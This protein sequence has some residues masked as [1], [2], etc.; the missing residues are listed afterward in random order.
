MRSWLPCAGFVVAGVG[1]AMPAL[2][3]GCAGYSAAP[4]SGDGCGGDA[5]M[6]GD[7]PVGSEGGTT[8]DGGGGDSATDGHP[9]GEAGITCD[10]ATA[11]VCSGVCVDKETDPANCGTCEHACSGPEAG[12]GHPVCAGGQCTVACD[13]DAG[14][15]I[16][17]GSACV[18]KETDPANCNTCG[19]KCPGPD[20]GSGQGICVN[21]ACQISCVSDAGTTLFCPTTG[22]CV[23]PM[24]IANCGGCGTV[25]PAPTA[26]GAASCTGSPLACGFACT[27]GYHPSGGSA[28]NA[29]CAANTDDP[30]VDP[31]VVADG[32]GV[33]VSAAGS[34]SSPG[35]GTKEH[36]YATI[37]YAMGQ[38]ATGVKR[39]YAC[40]AFAAP[41]AV[42]AA[43]DGVTVY[44]GFNCST[45]AYSAA[46][47]TTVAPTGAG[48]ALQV[49]GLT[50][51]VTFEDFAF[52]AVSA[53]STPSAT[54]A[55]SI[56]VFVNASPLTLTRV[57]VTAGSGQ[58]GVGGGT[59][60]NYSSP[61]APGGKAPANL[62]AGGAGGGPNTCQDGSTSSG[63]TGA[64]LGGLPSNGTPTVAP[65]NAGTSGVSSCTPGGTGDPGNPGSQGGTGVTYSGTL[66]VSGWT[67]GGVGGS[68]TNGFIGEGGGGGGSNE[69]GGAGPGGGGGAGGCG[70]GAGTGGYTGGSSIGILSFQA[71][72]TT[73]ATAITALSGGMGGGSGPGQAGQTG[74]GAG[75]GEGTGNC[76]G[77]SGSGA[78]GPGGNGGDGTAGGGGAGG[79]SSGIVWTG[80]AGQAPSFNGTSYTTQAAPV[81]GITLGAQGPGGGNGA[82]P[83]ADAIFKS[84]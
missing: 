52:S 83:A 80:T 18:D 72:L 36:P 65:G 15:S 1:V 49:T 40:G 77:G 68:G 14:T 4:C 45:W 24:G 78:G 7:S 48:Y 62:A 6:G 74:G 69:A 82:T 75:S 42:V 3:Y 46:T 55:S 67:P 51:G 2:V 58:P 29:T 5:S 21:A 63:G 35:N 27:T 70:G 9:G 60:S 19:T 57:A 34:D 16:Y 22:D 28:C 59:T 33:F 56:A 71:M 17:C 41:L 76:V 81:A 13:S 73:T 30:S 38:A 37:A 10:A 84:N 54:P 61:T 47:P 8:H 23:D 43:D 50:T 66:S 32:L 53:P 26:N 12:A 11:T 64:A 44:G 31:C 39:V 79:L 25:C 20:S